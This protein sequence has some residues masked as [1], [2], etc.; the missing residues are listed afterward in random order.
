MG[1]VNY[2]NK[3]PKTQN[4]HRTQEWTGKRAESLQKKEGETLRTEK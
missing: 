3:K 1:V 4:N 2:A